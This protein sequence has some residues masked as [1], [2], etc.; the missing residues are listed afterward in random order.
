M[1]ERA[2]INGYMVHG[3]KYT[4]CGGQKLNS[5]FTEFLEQMY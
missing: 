4:T 1:A 5:K 2:P 3:V